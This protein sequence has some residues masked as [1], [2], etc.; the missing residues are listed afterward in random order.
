MA[1][2]TLVAAWLVESHR[3]LEGDARLPLGILYIAGELLRQGHEVEIKDCQLEQNGTSAVERIRRVLQD[4]GGI[5]GI[6]CMSNLLPA[7]LLAITRYKEKFPNSVIV[8]GGPGPS[9]VASNILLSFPA[10]DYIVQGEGEVTLAELVA[11]LEDGSDI[12]NVSGLWYRDDKGAIR[13]GIQRTRVKDLD[14]LHPLPYA[15]MRMDLYHTPV[16]ISTSRGCTYGCSFCDVSGLWKREVTQRNIDSVVSEIVWL[17]SK[18]KHKFSIVDDTFVLNPRRVREFCHKINQIQLPISWHCNGRIDLIDETLL[19]T[20]VEAGC[21]SMFFGIESGSDTVLRK[22]R[23]GFNATQ[24]LSSIDLAARYIPLVTASF[25]WGFP[26]ETLSDFQETRELYLRLAKIKN[27][28]LQLYE[29]T[30]FANAPIYREFSSQLHLDLD[31][32]YVTDLNGVHLIDSN[33]L[34]II[35]EHPQIFPNFYRFYT[36]NKEEKLKI[37]SIDR[38][39]FGR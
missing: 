36:P 8:L 22:L 7:V 25:I 33:E 9:S 27:V 30:P 19:E 3:K 23:K 28:K 18:G 14:S 2:V 1:K 38:E 16:P 12:N 5:I 6:S 32:R 20:M 11:R 26:Y 21:C 31:V 37:I 4:D 13:F 29:L 24:A 34:A 35:K 15:T 17:N 39:L 10:V